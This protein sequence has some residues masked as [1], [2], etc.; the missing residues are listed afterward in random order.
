MFLK[1]GGR[2][3]YFGDSLGVKK[4]PRI[5]KNAKTFKNLSLVSFYNLQTVAREPMCKISWIDTL[6]PKTSLK[7]I[8]KLMKTAF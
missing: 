6:R 7:R 3:H 4:Y 2:L 1:T 8:Q 5:S